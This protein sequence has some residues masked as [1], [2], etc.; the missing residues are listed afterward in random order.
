MAIENRRPSP[1]GLIHS[2]HGTQFTSW[3]FTR[4]A[5]DSGLV[6]SMGSIGD[7]FDKRRR[8]V[9]LG[10]D[11]GRAAST[12][13][14]RRPGS[15]SPTQSSTTWRSSTRQA[16]AQRAR[17]ANTDRVRKAPHLPIGSG[18]K[19]SEPTP[20]NQG[21]IKSTEVGQS[22]PRTRTSR[23][24]AVQ[25]LANQALVDAGRKGIDWG[26]TAYR[27]PGRT[28]AGC[29][30]A[31]LQHRVHAL[32]DPGACRRRCRS[33]RGRSAASGTRHDRPRTEV[34]PIER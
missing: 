25:P 12:G 30:R 14:D 33:S 10:Q 31:T 6:P 20:R 27:V 29:S 34:P 4:P 5:L 13:G 11:A 23:E 21:Y 1:G 26:L 24:Q 8:R 7:C 2:D 19:S 9:V 17:D 3:A 28:S 15:S 16:P 22:H 32:V 18:M